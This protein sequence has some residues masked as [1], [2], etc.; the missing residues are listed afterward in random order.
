ML[1]ARAALSPLHDQ[2][3]HETSHLSLPKMTSAPYK[4]LLA[5]GKVPEPCVVGEGGRSKTALLWK[6]LLNKPP[7][8]EGGKK[9]KSTATILMEKQFRQ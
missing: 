3:H 8:S 5:S 7:D 6:K 1:F 9:K 4:T 2:R